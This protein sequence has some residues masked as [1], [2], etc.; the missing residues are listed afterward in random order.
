LITEDNPIMN[1][2]IAAAALVAFSAVAAAQTL[3]D[4]EVKKV[5]KPAARITLKHGEIKQFDM[6]PMTGAY[7]VSDPGMLDKVQPGDHVKFSLD[8]LNNQY[9]IT[10][11]DV[12]K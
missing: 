7:K 2:I 5:D 12:V 4:A 1:R 9:T 10:K 8:R 6:P 3:V 11:I